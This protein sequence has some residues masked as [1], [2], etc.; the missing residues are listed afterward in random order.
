M[1]WYNKYLVIDFRYRTIT[2]VFTKFMNKT[3]GDISVKSKKTENILTIL[4]L[5]TIDFK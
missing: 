5:K 1:T 3:V 2:Q 4:C